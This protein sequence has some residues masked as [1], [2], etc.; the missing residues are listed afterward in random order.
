MLAMTRLEE[1][2]QAAGAVTPQSRRGTFVSY[3][4]LVWPDGRTDEFEGRA[5][6]TLVW[7]PR[8][9]HGHGY[10]PMFQPD[11]ATITFAEMSEEEKNRL[12]HRARSFAR[13]AESCLGR[14]APG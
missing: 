1:R 2:L 10:D 9:T 3:L 4:C 5:D 7:P 13:F 14:S 11:G 6:G 12:S 8:G